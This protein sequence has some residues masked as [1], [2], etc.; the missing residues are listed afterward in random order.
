M[1]LVIDSLSEEDV[2]RANLIFRTAFA[3]FLNVEP[4]SLWGDSDLFRTRWRAP[5]TRVI[6]ARQDGSLVGSNVLTRWGSLG[7][8]GPLTIEPSLWDKGIAKALMVET[9]RIFDEWGVTHRGLFTFSHS[10]K[11][12][13]LYQKFGYWPGRLTPIYSRTAEAHGASES[14][15]A[16]VVSFADLDQSRQADSLRQVRELGNRLLPGLD[17]TGEVLSVLDQKLGATLLRFDDGA[18]D[19]VAVCHTGAGSEAGSGNTYLK[20]GAIAP[21]ANREPRLSALLRGVEDFALSRR[22]PSIGLGCN[23]AHRVTSA[24]LRRSGYR[25]EFVGVSMLS[26]DDGAYHRDEFDVLDDL[27]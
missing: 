23:T 14:P 11:H 5:N 26:P 15:L 8:F 4:E 27:R 13:G 24:V 7:W 1:S 6:A 9:E 3:K 19:G 17:V 25:P 2:E 20:F 10:P 16:N 12:I 22:A 21:G 18:L